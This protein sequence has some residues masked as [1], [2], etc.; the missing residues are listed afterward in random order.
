MPAACPDTQVYD[1]GLQ[2]PATLYTLSLLHA[3]FELKR[4]IIRNKTKMVTSTNEQG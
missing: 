1:I 2:Q 4:L 3:A